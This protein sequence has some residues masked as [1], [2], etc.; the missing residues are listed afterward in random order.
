MIDTLDGKVK[1]K[2]GPETQN[3]TKVKLKGK[4]FTVYKKDNEHGDLYVTFKVK[5]PKGLSDKEKKLFSE[6]SKLR[7]HGK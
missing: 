5:I 7:G 4:G 3:D 2:V 6:L 1:V